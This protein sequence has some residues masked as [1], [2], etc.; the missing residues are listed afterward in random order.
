MDDRFL[1]EGRREPRP[2]FAAGLRERLSQ[3]HAGEMRRGWRVAGAPG[4]LAPAFAAAV[5]MLAVVMVFAVPSLR[6]YAQSFLD[7]F[8]VRDFAAVQVSPER[9]A[10]FKNG[11]IDMKSLIGDHVET[12]KEH[13]PPQFFQD[14]RSA[15]AAAGF[16]VRVPSSLPRG[17]QA[18][19]FTVMGDG[20]ARL[21]VDTAKLRELLNTLGINDVTIPENLNGAQVTLHM[22]P[23]VHALYRKDRIRVGL[24]EARS[25]EVSMP[26]GLDLARIGEIGLRIAGLS[27]SEAHRFAQSIDW[28]GTLVMPVPADV[29]SFT[30][31]TVRGHKGLLVNT[32]GELQTEK[33]GEL[34]KRPQTVLVW[35]ENDIVYGLAG[36]LNQVELMEMANS[37]H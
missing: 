12:L 35:T 29:S 15:G 10:Q 28:H 23:A 3:Q 36:N 32:T 7:L 22:N 11:S 25:P 16:D 26:A 8:R 4:G 9:L 1:H 2:E 14:P 30:Q 19:T 34:H 21:T 6:A 18:D 31:V 24:M 20:A 5:A 27:P 37:L 17:I 33:S 13:G